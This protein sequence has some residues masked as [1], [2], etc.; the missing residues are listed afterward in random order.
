MSN[1][2][3]WSVTVR[4]KLH[5]A[6]LFEGS[7]LIQLTA[8]RPRGKTTLVGNPPGEHMGGTVAP[9]LSLAETFNSTV[10]LGPVE[11]AGTVTELGQTREGAWTSTTVRVKLQLARL[12]LVSL[13][14]QRMIREPMET[15]VPMGGSHEVMLICTLSA[16][17]TVQTALTPFKFWLA[18]STSGLAGHVIVGGTVSIT[19][20]VLRHVALLPR[21]SQA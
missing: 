6:M 4:L 18:L 12:L 21:A 5:V 16:V 3:V 15:N 17:P 10:A 2:G 19:V 9:L 7:V 11:E 20:T 8:V 13:V 14:T 1:G